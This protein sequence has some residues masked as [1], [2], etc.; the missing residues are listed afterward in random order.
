M[1]Q[2]NA[3]TNIPL[4]QLPIIAG[5]LGLKR[6]TADQL[7]YWLYKKR[8]SSFDEMTNLPKR[9]RSELSAK[10]VIDAVKLDCAQKASDGTVKF[11]CRARDGA[12]VECVFIPQE[13]DR[14]TVCLSTEV[15]C[16]MG[17][18]FCRTAGMGFV[19]DLTQ[20]EILGQMILIMREKT[21]TITNV[22]L[23]GMGEP[24]ANIGAVSGAVEILLEAHAFGFSKR[25]VTLSTSGLLPQL[26]SFSEKFDIKLAISLNATTDEIRNRLMP[27][28]RR[29][30]IAKIMDFCREYSNRSRHRITFEYVLIKGVNDSAVDIQRLV[31]LLVGIRAKINLIPFNSFDGCDFSAPDE[32]TAAR[33]ADIL[34]SHGIQ[35]NIRIGRGQDILA[36]C[37]Q[38]AT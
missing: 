38:L 14:N 18:S 37:G 36:A 3:I 6:Y 33:W 12:A 8:V 4:A 30:P 7:I 25:R 10:Y 23:M 29:Y 22:V 21:E 1:P 17:C 34:I 19:R 16:A 20:G 26:K 28:N 31:K 15:G 9:V 13:D 27:I 5:Q 11:L 35:A 24:L 32:G 2:L